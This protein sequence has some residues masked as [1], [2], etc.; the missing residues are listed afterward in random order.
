MAVTVAR[1]LA[2]KGN[3]TWSISPHATVY[4]AIARMAEK[5]IGALLVLDGEQLVGIVSERDYARK[6]ILQDRS[7]RDT[8]VSTIMTK[9][10]VSVRPDQS[11]EGC[12]ALMTEKHIRHLPVVQ[13]GKV[14]G[15]L[16]IGDL[17]KFI[18]ADHELLIQQ[19]EGYITGR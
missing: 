16:S 7:S 17:V 1:L 5:G 8:L 19:L 6:V 3:D 10:V 11:I 13:D 15:I 12:M 9:D 18:I 4:E 14:V 2:S